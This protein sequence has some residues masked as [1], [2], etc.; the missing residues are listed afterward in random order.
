M[1]DSILEILYHWPVFLRDYKCNWPENRDE[2]N[3]LVCDLE[4]RNSDL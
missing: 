2:L 1:V 3:V 4:V